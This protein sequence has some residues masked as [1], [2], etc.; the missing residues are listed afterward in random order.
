MSY[1]AFDTH[2]GEYDAWYDSEV[3][4][5]IFAMEEDCL[6]PLL[7]RHKRPYLE[8]GVG[9]GRFGETLGIE[10]GVDPAPAPLRMAVSRGIRALKATGERLPFA[11]G[12]FGGILIALTLCFVDDP[13][14]VLQE[15]RRVLLPGGGLVLE[16]LSILCL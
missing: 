8:I 1:Q 16:S 10:Y 15:A 3:E 2:A 4:S 9:S 11:D 7:N 14:S 5:T 13:A 12:M 6:R